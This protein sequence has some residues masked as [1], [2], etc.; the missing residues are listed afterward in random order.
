MSG[1]SKI[2]FKDPEA[3]E[4]FVC[5]EI[6]ACVYPIEDFCDYTVNTEHFAE[7][8]AALRR[9]G[10]SDPLEALTSE[11]HASKPETQRIDAMWF[12]CFPQSAVLFKH[13][14]DVRGDYVCLRD[15]VV[16]KED[17]YAVFMAGDLDPDHQTTYNRVLGN[18]LVA[19]RAVNPRMHRDIFAVLESLP[20][21][22]VLDRRARKTRL[23]AP[24]EPGFWARLESPVVKLRAA[25]AV[26]TETLV[27]V[28]AATEA[29]V[30]AFV[31]RASLHIFL[32]VRF[33]GIFFT[34][35]LRLKRD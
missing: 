24:E 2:P 19:S 32:V 28:A 5:R 15:S 27:A 26:V 3:L 12:C 8:V 16:T 30:A 35:A 25:Q 20:M 17:V 13:L 10:D 6:L 34:R 31:V 11:V 7:S 22:L 33:V 29:A 23:A 9:L 4:D 14:L 21:K 18:L 1:Y